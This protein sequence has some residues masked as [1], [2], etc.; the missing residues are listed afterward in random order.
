M[1][2]IEL[3]ESR[4]SYFLRALQSVLQF[5]SSKSVCMMVLEVISEFTDFVCKLVAFLKENATS[6]DLASHSLVSLSKELL[7]VSFQ[8]YRKFLLEYVHMSDPSKVY[9]FTMVV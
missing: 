5:S 8:T 6:S 4:R 9:F 2:L 3:I 7:N 1:I